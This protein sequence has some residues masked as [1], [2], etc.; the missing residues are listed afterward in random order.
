MAEVKNIIYAPVAT[1]TLADCR[2]TYNFTQ[3]MPLVLDRHGVFRTTRWY[4]RVWAKLT[5]PFRRRVIV[6]AVDVDTGTITVAED[7]KWYRFL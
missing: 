3:G 2:D 1:I 6:A 4:D 7:P 5:A